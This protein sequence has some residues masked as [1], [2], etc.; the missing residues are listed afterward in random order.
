MNSPLQQ[1]DLQP[2]AVRLAGALEARLPVGV[3]DVGLGRWRRARLAELRLT[4]VAAVPRGLR[5]AIDGIGGD[6]TGLV[7]GVVV[8]GDEGRVDR[9]GVLDSAMRLAEAVEQELLDLL[10]LL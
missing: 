6:Q 5:R 2:R 1:A 3:R 9:E 8:C 7:V 4:L 10:R